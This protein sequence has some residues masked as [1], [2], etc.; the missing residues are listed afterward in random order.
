MRNEIPL[1]IFEFLLLG[2]SAVLFILAAT[3][4]N[5]NE[6]RHRLM[7]WGLACWVLYVL[8]STVGGMVK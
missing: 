1:G 5:G 3:N 8:L 7:S 6:D 2:L 4:R